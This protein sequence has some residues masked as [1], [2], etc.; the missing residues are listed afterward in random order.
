[1]FSYCEFVVSNCIFNIIYQKIYDN[2]KAFIELLRGSKYFLEC[3]HILVQNN[4][5]NFKRNIFKSASNTF[6][7]AS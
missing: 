1:M 6:F 7:L 4:L 2:T 3:T 5:I